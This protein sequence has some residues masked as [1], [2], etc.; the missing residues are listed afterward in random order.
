MSWQAIFMRYLGIDYGDKRIGIALSDELGV[1]AFPFA[2]VENNMK[3]INEIKKICS[4]Q[5]VDRIV[6]GLPLS[7][8]MKET[9]QTEKVRI[10]VKKMEKEIKLPIEFENEILT[11]KM[12]GK[13]GVG[14]QNIDESSAALILQSWLDKK[15]KH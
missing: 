13:Q 14:K 5:G 7:F 3:A 1:L 4:E 15:I 12:A 2:T 6:M 8:A 10:F 9:Q 11:S